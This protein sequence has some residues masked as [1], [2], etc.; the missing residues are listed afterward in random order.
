MAGDRAGGIYV[1]TFGDDRRLESVV[2][3]RSASFNENGVWILDDS[4]KTEFLEGRVV[5][6]KG[7]QLAQPTALSR[8]G[9]GIGPRNLSARRECG[10]RL[11]VGW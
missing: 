5:A 3:A 10:L 8:N 9:D 6:T 1:F 7:A 11:G 2:Q 4:R